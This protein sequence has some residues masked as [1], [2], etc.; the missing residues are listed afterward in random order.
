MRYQST[1]LVS[2]ITVLSGVKVGQW[3]QL[4]TGQ[5]GQFLGVTRAGVN[6][7]RWQNSKFQTVDA[8]ANK[9]LRQFAKLYGAMNAA[10][11]V[12]A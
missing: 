10:S 7:V 8:K 12:Q 1:L 9:P 11:G 6:V 2:S 3:I 4:E 5:R